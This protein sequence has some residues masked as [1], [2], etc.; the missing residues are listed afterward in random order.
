MS[1]SGLF[2]LLTV[3]A[4]VRCDRPRRGTRRRWLWPSVVAH[5][6]A[7]L[8]KS[9]TVT[10]PARAGPPGR[11]SAS[12]APG[13]PGAAG[14]GGSRPEGAVHAALASRMAFLAR[15]NRPEH[16][17][18][19]SSSRGRSLSRVLEPLV[20][21]DQDS[22]A[23]RPLAALP[24]PPAGLH[25]GAPA[26]L[27]PRRASSLVTMLA[28][29]A[30]TTL[31]GALVGLDPTWSCWPRGRRPVARV[32]LTADRYS[33]ALPGLRGLGR[34]GVA[35]ALDGSGAA[36]DGALARRATAG[37]VIGAVWPG[38]G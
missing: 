37:L 15:G 23:R 1:S 31:P 33:S 19:S 14:V 9:I 20:L 17:G 35:V 34:G 32:H 16:F 3:L 26:S 22:R 36:A 2:L 11:L 6:A 7:L 27:A 10:A 28:S 25:L 24:M 5:S 8:S 13:A 18:A 4:Y 30:P 38:A 29:A 12:P 21:P